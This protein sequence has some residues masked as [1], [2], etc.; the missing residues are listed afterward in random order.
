MPDPKKISSCAKHTIERLQQAG[1]DA[2]IVGGAVRD[3]LLDRTPKDFDIA[4]DATPEQVKE[5]FGRRCRI[6]GRRFRLAHVYG[7]HETLEVSTFRREPSMKERRG[8]PSDKGVMVWRDNEFGNL[9]QDAKR[10]DFTVN[11]LFYDPFN[12]DEPIT[13]LVDG[14]ADMEAGIVR[15]IG[16]PATRLGEDPVRM[17]R[18]LKLVAQYDFKLEPGLETALRNL[19][20]KLGACSVARLLEEL[21]K[22]LRKEWSEPTLDQLHHYG[23]LTPLLPEVAGIWETSRG[24]RVRSLLRQRDRLL[25]EGSVYP[26]RV[27]GMAALLIPH[28]YDTFASA[29]DDNFLW[30]PF[31]GFEVELRH[32][33]RDYF[34]PLPISQFS[35][36]KLRDTLVLL[37]KLFD[38]GQ[39]PPN[40]VEDPAYPRARD[41]FRILAA[42]CE[43]D[44]S[45]V[46][47]LPEPVRN[48]R[49]PRNNLDNRPKRRRRGGRGRNRRRG[50]RRESPPPRDNEGNEQA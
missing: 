46:E 19:A 37:P 28:L 31:P 38:L 2:H 50:P 44:A 9:E 36:A 29:G 47:A 27:T 42:S 25:A 3:I 6:I 7:R 48:K 45:L 32:E 12:D 39:L 10:R 17:L 35:S 41:L 15:T 11:A 16:D 18:A 21:Y 33:V 30:T 23:L 26:S 40:F 13:D 49:P 22:I 8:R 24:E 14:M 43:L 20:P 34:K 4:T 5:V 1:Y